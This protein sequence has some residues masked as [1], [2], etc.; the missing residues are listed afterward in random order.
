MNC[1]NCG[2]EI[3]N[4]AAFCSNCGQATNN[5]NPNTCKRCGAELAEGAAFCGNCG[6]ATNNNTPAVCK[7]CGRELS[8]GSV[9]C[10]YCGAS[11]AQHQTPQPDPAATNQKSRLLAGLLAILLGAF[12]VHNFYLG[13]MGKAVTQL[14]LGLLGCTIV[15]SAIWGL[16]E[17]ILIL[18]QDTTDAAGIPLKKDA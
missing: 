14:I 8:A 16:I 17:G 6:Q 3:I 1:K 18:T 5:N 4:G 15:I 7:S 2:A 13:F 10:P 11:T 9:F 12:G